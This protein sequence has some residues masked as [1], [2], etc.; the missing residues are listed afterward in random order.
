M[1]T[2][3]LAVGGEGSPPPCPPSGCEERCERGT[4]VCGRLHGL[5]HPEALAIAVGCDLMPGRLRQLNKMQ[6]VVAKRYQTGSCVPL[7]QEVQLP[8]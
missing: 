5:R 8:V 4:V 6:V 3:L 1:H 7:F 2:K